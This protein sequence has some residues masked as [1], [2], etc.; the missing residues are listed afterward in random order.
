[1]DRISVVTWLER[2]APEAWG[3]NAVHARTLSSAAVEYKRREDGLDI[4]ASPFGSQ[5][6]L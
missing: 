4:A 1:M 3:G 5:I 6:L 2:D